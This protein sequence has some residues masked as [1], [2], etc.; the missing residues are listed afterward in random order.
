GL[1]AA[2]QAAAKVFHGAVAEGVGAVGGGGEL[3]FGPGGGR[4]EAGVDRAEVRPVRKPHDGSGSVVA[5]TATSV[6]AFATTTRS[7]GS[8]S[9]D[10]RRSTV[11]RGSTATIRAR[12]PSSPL[13]SPT[14]LTRSPGTMARRR[15]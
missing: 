15:R 8:V 4:G 3:V 6:S 5:V 2:V 13:V 14:M 11:V 10:E 1:A 12:V 9:S 7:V